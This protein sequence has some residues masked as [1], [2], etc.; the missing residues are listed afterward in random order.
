MERRQTMIVAGIGCREACTAA[1]ILAAI[2]LALRQTKLT[3]RDIDRICTPSFKSRAPEIA[4][5]AEMLQR[6]LVFLDLDTLA[7]RDAETLTHSPHVATRFGLSSIAE[8]AALAGAG[9]SSR[10]CGPRL[11]YGGAT[12]ALA[13][14]ELPS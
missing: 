8:T 10:L 3:A 1:D 2:G 7:M 14:S 9:A 12:C 6:P 13:F 11:A 4:A 5:A